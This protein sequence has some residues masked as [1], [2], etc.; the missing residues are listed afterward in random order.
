MR[1]YIGDVIVV[2]DVG[3]INSGCSDQAKVVDVEGGSIFGVNFI[4]Y[5]VEFTGI[6]SFSWNVWVDEEKMQLDKSYYRE[7][8][9]NQLGI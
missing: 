6:K 1:Y 7:E 9:L 8:K 4:H 5:K 2:K 3:K